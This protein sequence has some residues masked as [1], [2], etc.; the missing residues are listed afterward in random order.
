M[1]PDSTAGGSPSRA[2]RTTTSSD[3]VCWEDSHHEGKSVRRGWLLALIMGSMAGWTRPPIPRAGR[4]GPRSSGRSSSASSN[5][6]DP[7]IPDRQT[8]AD[9]A[10][11]L[12]QWFRA[13]G[14]ANRQQLLFQDFGNADPGSRRRPPPP[15]CRRKRT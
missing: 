8:A 3:S 5:Y 1:P 12:V 14:W 13:A 4:S 15:S 7:A 10:R 11:S 9:H 6:S 2:D